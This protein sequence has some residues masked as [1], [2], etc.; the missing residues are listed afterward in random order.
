MSTVNSIAK[1]DLM[2]LGIDQIHQEIH[3]NGGAVGRSWRFG[4]A[5]P[6]NAAN[7]TPSSQQV[8][9]HIVLDLDGDGIADGLVDTHELASLGAKGISELDI[10]TGSFTVN[11]QSQ[12]MAATALNADS[13]GF[14]TKTLATGATACW[15]CR[16]PGRPACW[17]WRC[18]T[19]SRPEPRP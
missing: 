2:T 16:R 14:M 12:S 11:G 18:L 19:P 5:L 4:D 1:N 9:R 15:C 13:A 3:E 17:R 6:R 7:P 8:L 10:A